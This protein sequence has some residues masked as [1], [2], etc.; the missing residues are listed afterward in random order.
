MKCQ[1]CKNQINENTSECE[2]CGFHINKMNK[3]LPAEI[4]GFSLFSHNNIAFLYPSDY[5]I[6]IEEDGTE[7]ILIICNKNGIDEEFQIQN[8][9]NDNRSP[10]NVINDCI[11]GIKNEKKYVFSP[12]YKTKFNGINCIAMDFE[13]KHFFAR[14][15]ATYYSFNYNDSNFLIIITTQ[16]K[17]NL[18]SI[19]K[20]MERSFTIL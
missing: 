10:E 13:N 6:S 18:N 4:E 19:Y 12:F 5:N 11:E 2:W 20:I 8:Y 1:N 15:C 7:M 9:K 16:S 14:D 17:L 3:E